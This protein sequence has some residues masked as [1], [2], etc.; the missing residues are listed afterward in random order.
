MPTMPRHFTV[1]IMAVLACVLT[2]TGSAA[3]VHGETFSPAIVK[4]N[5]FLL[6]RHP[7]T[8]RDDSQVH[9]LVGYLPSGTKVWVGQATELTNLTEGRRETYHYVYSELGYQG[10]LREDLFIP[11]TQ[12]PIA[13]AT[14]S[15]DIPLFQPTATL[16]SMKKRL[17]LGRY[18]GN[19]LEIVGES[20]PGFYDVILHRANPTDRY[21]ARENCR[22]WKKHEQEGHVSVV[23]PESVVEDTRSIPQWT[24]GLPLDAQ[25]IDE[26]IAAVQD[27]YKD[28]IAAIR[29]FLGDL[30]N[31]QCLVG[32]DANAE[33]GFKLFSTGLAF[34]L[35]M[36]VK[37]QAHKYTFEKYQIRSL[38]A[39][40]V[41]TVLRNIRCDG[42][43]PER[44]EQ[45]TIQEGAYNPAKRYRVRL[46]DLKAATTKWVTTLQGAAIP[47]KMIR[48]SGF[49]TYNRAI[50]E[51][52][53]FA[54]TGNGYL[55]TLSATD[56]AVI[57]NFILSKIAYFE[58]RDLL[59]DN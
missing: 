58:H 39:Q 25:L 51:L 54:T 37:E 49:D 19:F 24:R 18:G 45:I 47:D 22:L 23:R 43:D 13:V 36:A 46:K 26:I 6:S 42:A 12:N 17:T 55:S 53:D 38:K 9:S 27:T 29:G 20:E 33:L 10:L 3:A 59:I 7:D 16:E 44:L 30:S 40:K 4:L 56:R 57:L 35:D 34:N 14:A 31:L 28:Q 5:A 8:Q 32:A 11:V 52:E 50:Q 41:F 15:Y 21:P 2:V 48:I 1:V